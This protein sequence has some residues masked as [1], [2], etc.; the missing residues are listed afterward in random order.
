MLPGLIQAENGDILDPKIPRKAAKQTAR[1]IALDFATGWLI[2]AERRTAL[3]KAFED[4]LHQSP[5]KVRTASLP[6]VQRFLQSEQE[7]WC[8]ALTFALTQT[9][10]QR[11]RFKQAAYE[12]FLAHSS[13][14]QHIAPGAPAEDWN[15]GTEKRLRKLMRKIFGML[16]KK[17]KLLPETFE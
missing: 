7:A 2:E 13:L 10:K 3:R 11:R 6:T 12:R 5:E 16:P 1:S 8:L 4:V 14:A 15:V 9:P 17:K